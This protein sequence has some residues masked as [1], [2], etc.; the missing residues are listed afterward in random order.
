M[1]FRQFS[2][3][4]KGQGIVEY[5]VLIAFVVAAS[6]YLVSIVGVRG[7]ISNTLSETRSVISSTG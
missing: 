5:A 4:K 1:F 3:R 2:L 7:E 6:V